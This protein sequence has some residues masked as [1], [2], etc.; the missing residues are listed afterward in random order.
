MPQGPLGQAVIVLAPAMF[1]VDPKPGRIMAL[2]LS[3]INGRG[4]R[5]DAHRNSLGVDVS[6]VQ[7]TRFSTRY[8]QYILSQRFALYS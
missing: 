3:S 8:R 1:N 4:L 5:L 7:E 6:Y 2:W